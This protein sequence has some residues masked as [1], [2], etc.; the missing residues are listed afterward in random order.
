MSKTNR[1]TESLKE[2]I[3]TIH[4]DK[5]RLDLVEY[6]SSKAKITLVCNVHGVFTQRISEILNG[7][8]CKACAIKSVADKRRKSTEEFVEEIRE[9]HGNKYEYHLVEYINNKTPVRL[10]CKQHG[11]FTKHPRNLLKGGGCK[12][13]GFY[14]ISEK[15]KL[16]PDEF[17]SR[18]YEVHG[19]KYDYSESVYNGTLN[20]IEIFCKHHKRYFTQ[21]AGEHLRGR[22]C[23][24]CF[25]DSL[26]ITEEMYFEMLKTKR[27][28]RYIYKDCGFTSYSEPITITCRIHGRFKQ[29]A[30]NHL[31]GADCPTCNRLQSNRGF[32]SSSPAW[33][34]I[35]DI[36]GSAFNF[37]G[38]G[39]TGNVDIRLSQHRNNLFKDAFYIK[40]IET[41]YHEDGKV[42]LALEG[43]MKDRL[44]RNCKSSDVTGFKT[45]SCSLSFSETVELTKTLFEEVKGD[46]GNLGFN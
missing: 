1:T 27:G 44:P 37:T 8:G 20:T 2:E 3:R 22:G 15:N 24:E 32:D 18:C 46:Y 7:H 5:Y 35:L 9:V 45:E 34:Y 26:K 41:F 11:E 6:V 14:S 23:R 33:L 21:V 13:C 19:D 16:S 29:I 12:L 10:V 4:G 38:F 30:S 31:N 36:D 39:I 43:L 42:I 28:D 17:F 40:N 25:I